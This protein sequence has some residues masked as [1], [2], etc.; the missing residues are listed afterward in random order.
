M[1]EAQFKQAGLIP[2]LHGQG[3]AGTL[4][5]FMTNYLNEEAGALPCHKSGHGQGVSL[6]FIAQGKMEQ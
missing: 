4:A 2:D 6:I 1:E 3:A 5:N